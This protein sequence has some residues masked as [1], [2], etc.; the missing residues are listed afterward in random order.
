[1]ADVLG[2]AGDEVELH[3]PSSTWRFRLVQAVQA[4]AKDPDVV[5]ASWLECGA[6]MGLASPIEPGLL[7]PRVEP[8]P[9]RTLEELDAELRW[10]TNHPS[11]QEKHGEERPPGLALIEG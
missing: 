7:F 8:T 10:R 1:M 9:E 2:V 5:M 3:D 4:E 11:F 6:P